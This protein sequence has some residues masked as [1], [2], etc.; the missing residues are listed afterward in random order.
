VRS[1]LNAQD[2]ESPARLAR[3][4]RAFDASHLDA[5]TRELRHG[6]LAQ[7]DRIPSFARSWL[8]DDA[9]QPA[10]MRWYERGAASAKRQIVSALRTRSR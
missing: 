9:D 5:R 10:R 7:L 2:P 4:L 3:G 8:G 1:G 6:V